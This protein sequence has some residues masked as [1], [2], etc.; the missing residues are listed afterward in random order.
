MKIKLTILLFFYFINLKHSFSQGVLLGYS[1]DYQLNDGNNFYVLGSKRIS[2]TNQNKSNDGYRHIQNFY[3]S[4]FD[5]SGK[6]LW[7]IFINK[8]RNFRKTSTIKKNMG[9]F[10]VLFDVE[11]MKPELHIFYITH[12]LIKFDSLGNILDE[13]KLHDSTFYEFNNVFYTN[14]FIYVVLNRG[15]TVCEKYDYNF[16]LIEVFDD[17]KLNSFFY[18]NVVLTG[19]KNFICIGPTNNLS[20][21]NNQAINKTPAVFFNKSTNNSLKTVNI[22]LSTVKDTA[23]IF[24]FLDEQITHTAFE[25]GIAYVVTKSYA[26]NKRGK[27][28]LYNYDENANKLQLLTDTLNRSLTYVKRISLNEL[29]F[30]QQGL[31]ISGGNS[32]PGIHYPEILYHVRNNKIILRRELKPTK[33]D[34]GNTFFAIRDKKLFIST[35][36]FSD[37]TMSVNIYDYEKGIFVR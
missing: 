36:Y 34:V 32:G 11:N 19:K 33:E 16:K 5:L 9:N 26:P 14:N 21:I 29:L 13:R 27:N 35:I 15:K 3:I 7:E 8:N 22:E 17:E 12:F 18:D 6:K 1:S 30:V 28:K 4:K 23:L 20:N 10:Y 37:N 25:N 24:R 31:Y 2:A